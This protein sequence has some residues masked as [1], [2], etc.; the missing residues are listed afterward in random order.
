[1]D[2][3]PELFR[4][5][6]L[7]GAFIVLIG[8][9]VRQVVP[10]RQLTLNS[11]QQLRAEMKERIDELKAEV[12]ALTAAVIKCEKEH[13]ASRSEFDS[14]MLGLQKQHLQEQLTFARAIVDA[15]PEHPKLQ[16]LLR[17]LET[18]RKSITEICGPVS[19]RND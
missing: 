12:K 7:W 10:W 17:S 2:F 16:L 3:S 6:P 5:I 9:F 15:V 18:G 11:E 19:D 1:M 4:A 8:I 13:A 14:R